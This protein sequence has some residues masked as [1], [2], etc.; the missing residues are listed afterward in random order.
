[1]KIGKKSKQGDVID[2]RGAAPPAGGIGGLGGLGGMK[3]GGAGILAILV[4]L[5]GTFVLGGG[6]IGGG[7]G[8]GFADIFNRS[9]FGGDTL[10]TQ[11]EAPLPAHADPDRD[12]VEFLEFVTTDVN[13]TW[14]QFFADAG[15]QYQRAPLVLFEGQT[16]TAC[17]VGSEATGPFYCPADQM[18]Y[19]DVGFFEE[20]HEQFGAPGDFAAAY[21]IAHE[22]GH[23]IQTLTGI[24]DRVQRASQQNPDDANELSV[25][26]ELQADCFAGVW[27]FTTG[28][29][30]L[31]EEGDLEEALTAATA[32]GDDRI[33][34]SA[35]QR[36]NPETWT[37]GS[38]EQR[39]KW[40]RRGFET[41]DPNE[42]DTFSVDNP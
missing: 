22:I 29:R 13:D 23:H 42:C 40:F 8:G 36:V 15:Q 3:L 32:I 26:Q 34:A 18:A 7:G 16:N 39:V 28:Q 1:M 10:T 17:G 11:D 38:G 5:V 9:Q 4:A 20:L 30:G 35:G 41:G 33:Q 31:L 14:E 21:V 6:G 12:V 2:R 19:L 25:R 27:G 37:H 24:S